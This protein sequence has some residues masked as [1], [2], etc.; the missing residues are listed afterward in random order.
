MQKF[1]D[2]QGIKILNK[3]ETNFFF[4]L[5]ISFDSNKTATTL[6]F[7]SRISLLGYLY[8]KEPWKTKTVSPSEAE[9]KFTT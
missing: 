8:N 5:F 2:G 3:D 9:R 7:Y 4:Y 1:Y 6:S